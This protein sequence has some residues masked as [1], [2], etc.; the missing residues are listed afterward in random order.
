LWEYCEG[1]SLCINHLHWDGSI[2]AEDLYAWYNTNAQTED[3][4]P[5]VWPDA[6]VLG[7]RLPKAGEPFADAKELEGFMHGLILKYRMEDVFAVPGGAMQTQRDLRAMALHHCNYLKEHNVFFAETRFA[8]WYHTRKGLSM[9]EVIGYALQGFEE[10]HEKTGVRVRPIICINREVDPSVAID[11]VDAA[12]LYERDL[13]GIDLACM[14][15]GRPP[16]LFYDAFRKT[17]DTHL[18]RSVHA[19]EMCLS[20]NENLRNVH[21]AITKLRA[22][23]IGHAIP[24]HK[25]TWGGED[26]VQLMLDNNVRLE[27]NPVC[28]D[29]FYP[30]TIRRLHLDKLSEWGVLVTI[31]PDDPA[32]WPDGHLVDNLYAVGR[33]YGKEFVDKMVANSYVAAW[34]GE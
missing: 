22:D 16:E 33:L 31:N 18:K 7:K 14:E 3:K 20:E 25:R 26:L 8:P 5:L 15:Q 28:N 17:F 24:L 34:T 6:D 30:V 1:Q 23:G 32:M 27:S 4:P 2:L 10:A 19:G 9:S 11:I 21:T 12:L 29:R 13:A